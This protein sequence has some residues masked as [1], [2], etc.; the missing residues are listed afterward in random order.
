MMAPPRGRL[1]LA[2]GWERRGLDSGGGGRR[3]VEI[4]RPRH[5]GV[6]EDD[7][8]AG[9]VPLVA[10]A[11]VD[12]DSLVGGDVVPTRVSLQRGRVLVGPLRA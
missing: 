4:C 3:D 1:D 10:G 11:T 6:S 7:P 9:T 2:R 12:G 8:N 5:A